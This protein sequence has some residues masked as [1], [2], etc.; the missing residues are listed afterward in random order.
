[1]SSRANIVNAAAAALAAASGGSYFAGQ[2]FTVERKYLPA[3]KLETLRQSST[4]W[5]L[6][7]PPI[8]PEERSLITRGLIEKKFSFDIG[9]QIAVATACQPDDPAANAE[10]DGYLGFAEAV[11]HFFEPDPANGQSGL[12]DST[13]QASW[14]SSVIKPAYD[15]DHLRQYRVFTSR[16]ILTV[17]YF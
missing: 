7:L 2:T 13:P 12:I 6:T 11:A 1:M 5:I 16:V 3:Q 8:G 4:G 17:R 14:Y 15:P 9:I 10:L